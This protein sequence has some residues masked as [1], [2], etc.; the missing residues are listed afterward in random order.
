MASKYFKNDL[1]WHTLNSENCYWAGLI[2]A[3]GY[4]DIH[5]KRGYS[6]QLKLKNNDSYLIQ[7]LKEAI[8]YTGPLH[9]V[10]PKP[11][12]SKDK[13][14][15][16]NC[17]SQIR[18]MLFGAKRLIED[19]QDKFNITS[20]KSL[21]YTHPKLD[22]EE[23]IR[24]FI[25]GYIDGDGL[26]NEYMYA[27]HITPTLSIQICGTESFLNWIQEKCQIP[28]CINNSNSKIY[29]LRYTHLKARSFYDWITQ[30]GLGKLERK[31]KKKSRYSK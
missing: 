4:I 29:C 8:E 14:T 1:Y 22:S 19:L 2:A 31:W 11:V 12:Y 28:G 30:D 27:K 18:L 23:Y 24:A 17:G 21:S 15:W 9:I 7:E 3:D 16:H 26:I 6:I 5:P 10:Q 20:N 13:D 25:R